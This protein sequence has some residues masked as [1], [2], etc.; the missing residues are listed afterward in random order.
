MHNHHQ[1]TI[2]IIISPCFHHQLCVYTLRIEL[3]PF[4]NHIAVALFE[5]HVPS[6]KPFDKARQPIARCTAGYHSGA[7]VLPG[8]V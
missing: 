7:W 8:R 1:H 5:A 4:A 6:T 2:I 3:Q